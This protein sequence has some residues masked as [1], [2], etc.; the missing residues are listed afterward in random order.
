MLRGLSK[1]ARPGPKDP[2]VAILA[3]AGCGDEAAPA[4]RD[5]ETCGLPASL[6]AAASAA[7]DAAAAAALAAASSDSPRR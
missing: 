2:A 7:A 6:L 4:G 5:P 3:R 1:A